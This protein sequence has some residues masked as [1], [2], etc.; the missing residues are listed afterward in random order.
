[1]TIRILAGLMT[2]RILASGPPRAMSSP[3]QERGSGPPPRTGPTLRVGYQ[4]PFT[5]L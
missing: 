2:V 4:P 1:M 5:P 3:A